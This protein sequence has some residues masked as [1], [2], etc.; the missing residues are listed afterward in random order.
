MKP[1]EMLNM[2]AED[3]S[4]ADGKG[5]LHKPSDYKG[6]WIVLYFYPRDDTPGCTKEACSFRDNLSELK[7]QGIVVLGVSAD[8]IASHEKFAGKYKLN[9]PLLS[10]ENKAAVN[11]Y[12]VWQKKQFMGKEYYGIVRT[13]FLISPEGRIKRV[14]EHVKAEGHVLEILKDLDELKNL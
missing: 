2:R 3:F 1:S 6:K 9:F 14:Y 12:H 7:K 8:S 11:S 4:L 5:K 10:D 13:T